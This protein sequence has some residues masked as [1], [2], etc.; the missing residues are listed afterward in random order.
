MAGAHTGSG[1]TAPLDSLVFAMEESSQPVETVTATPKG[2]LTELPI[3]S[4]QET[5]SQPRNPFPSVE[6]CLDV[7]RE[8]YKISHYYE[9]LHYYYIT[10]IVLFFLLLL[11]IITAVIFL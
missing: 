6:Q 2:S 10:I 4:E 5:I 11:F 7:I 9:I 1:A 3:E 8:S